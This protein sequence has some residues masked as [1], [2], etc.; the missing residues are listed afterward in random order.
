[1]KNLQYKFYKNT[2]EVEKELTPD[3]IRTFTN[4]ELKAMWMNGEV[5]EKDD[6]TFWAEEA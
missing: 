6:I 4:S 3:E 5:I 2:N 1:M